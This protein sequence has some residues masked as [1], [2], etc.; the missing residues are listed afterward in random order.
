[1]LRAY[2][3][4]YLKSPHAPPK[5]WEWEQPR[6]HHLIVNARSFKT[7]RVEQRYFQD[8]DELARENARIWEVHYRSRPL[9]DHIET[10]EKWM[11][12]YRQ[13]IIEVQELYE[14]NTA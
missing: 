5:L 4:I 11:A 12:E 3:L 7:T 14:T 9:Y 10:W 1:M 6:I 13:L 2:R 8:G